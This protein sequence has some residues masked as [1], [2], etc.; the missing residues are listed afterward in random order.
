[1]IIGKPGYQISEANAMDYVWGYTII[2]DYTARERQRDHKQFF[3]G[4]S[5]DT[6]CPIG[7]VAVPKDYL[8]EELTVQTFVNGEKRQEAS[9]GQLIFSIPFLVKTLSEG[10][11]LQPGDV[12]AT[13]T[14]AGVGFGFRPMKFLNPGDEVTVQVTGLGSLTNRISSAQTSN[15]TLERISAK[16]DIPV[17]NSKM[18]DIQTPGLKKVGSKFLFY[19]RLEAKQGSSHITFIHGLGSSF[20]YFTA[21]IPSLQENN[22]LH[23]LDL[24]GHGL[25]PTSADGVLSIASYAED[26][27][28][29]LASEGVSETALVAHSMGSLIAAKLVIDNPQLVTKVV[30][31]GPPPS[32]LPEAASNGSK[33]RAKLVR[34]KGMLEV[35]DALAAS[36][37]SEK[38]KSTNLL[39]IT[40]LRLALTSQHPEGYAKGCTA[41]ASAPE[42]DFSK[43][44]CPTLI[45]TGEEDKVSPPALCEQYGK[46]LTSSKIEVLEHVGH[47]HLFEDVV[48]V[49]QSVNAFLA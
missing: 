46:K 41:L 28:A 2:N 32:P 38:T 31:M 12:L 14:P 16:T 9:T 37:V 21:L 4:K 6:F 39:A 19:R 26:I 20:D 25:S 7:P 27:S 36:A 18:L 23:L 5:P 44:A 8:P 24:E 13:G 45:V 34:Q 10:Q 43:I 3:I 30:L 48:K 22:T 29:L 49:T 15:A 11:A 35:V 42:L 47:W 1:M 33:A 40:A 17:F